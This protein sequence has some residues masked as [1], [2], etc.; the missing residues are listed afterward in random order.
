MMETILSI[1]MD[2]KLEFKKNSDRRYEARILDRNA[3]II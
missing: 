2:G 3:E 1:A